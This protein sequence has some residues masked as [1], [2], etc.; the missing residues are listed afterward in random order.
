MI[1]DRNNLQGIY[2]SFSTIFRQ[3]FDGAPSQCDTVA[4]RTPS[5]ARSNDY[6][7]L[8]SYP[9]MKEWIGDRRIKDLSAFHFEIVNKDFE[10]TVELDRNDI[11]DDQVGGYT[12]SL[13]GLG[14]AAK[15]H[16]DVLVF[17]LLKSGFTTPCYDRQY[18]F[19][20]DHPV[21]TKSVSNTG[22]GS[23]APWFLMDLSRPLKPV[24][25][26]EKTYYPSRHSG[27]NGKITGDFPI[28]TRNPLDSGL[29]SKNP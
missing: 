28:L 29:K 3:A 21:G 18:F 15:Q 12:P 13:Q 19:D 1:V 8:G 22:G 4:M 6:K 17:S 24:R 26:S 10:S 2:R 14:Q 16:P 20:S 27:E 23:G 9:V 25:D 11:E 7:W 5:S